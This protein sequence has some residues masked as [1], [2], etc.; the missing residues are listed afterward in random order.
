MIIE[1]DAP[2][3]ADDGLVLRADIF[4]PTGDGTH[5]VI[6]TY[7]PYGKG[8]PF[9]RNYPLAW[10]E[11]VAEFPEILEGTS[12]KYINFETADPEK[13]VP[14]GYA[15]IRVDS[16]G[17]GRSPGFMDLLSERETQDLYDC[18]EWAAAQPWS[19]GRVGLNGI[20]YYAMNQWQVATLQPPHLAAC[21]LWEGAADSYRDS[22]YHGGIR[23]SFTR[24]Y[25]DSLIVPSEYGYACQHGLGEVGDRNPLTGQLIC[26]DETLTDDERAACRADMGSIVSEHPFIDDYHR[27]RTPDTGRITVPLLSAGNWGGQ[28][29]HL[30]GNTVGFMQ[31][32][33][34]E[35]WLEMHES[36]HFMHFY[37][38][39]GV[40]LQKR[41]FG[42]FLK[43][44]DTGW[45]EEP[46]VQM[47]VRHVDG[48]VERRVADEWPLPATQWTPL[49]LDARDGSLGPSVPG[50]EASGVYDGWVGRLSFSYSCPGP[51]E[52]IGPLSAKLF[53]E[54]VTSDADLFLVVRAFSPD[55]QEVVFP[56]A[57]DPHTP[58]AQGWLRASHRALDEEK[59]R[60]YL[61]V[62][63][64]DKAEPLTPGAI[65]ELDVEILPTSLILPAGYRLVLDV[66]G[67]DYYYP[68]STDEHGNDISMNTPNTG[69][70][71]FLHT[72]PDDRPREIFGGRIRVH[73]GGKYPSHVLVPVIA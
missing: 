1:W 19:N 40:D 31:A 54:S 72:E 65:Y 64:H 38:D 69:C 20:S 4:R 23:T 9:E 51:V 5:P 44:D 50:E 57:I 37:T 62:H 59:S 35:K 25:F 13:W 45:I 60:R 61:P 15:C 39:Y 21:C 73:T 47:R 18:I 28:G 27:R 3:V 67:H 14:D 68:H 58:I 52:V 71:P 10:N 29:L 16:R 42:H 43:G 32:A 11:M 48:H 36:T 7:G 26:G 22:T 56:G 70:G 55:G 53:I 2:I 30:R 63:P 33:S 34:N 41:F 24:V 66:Q 17:A 49:Y 8:M 6:L 12:G 46:R